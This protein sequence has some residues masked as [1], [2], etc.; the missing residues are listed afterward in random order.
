MLSLGEPTFKKKEL[1]LIFL[2]SG[3]QDAFAGGR[4]C[5][6][7]RLLSGCGATLI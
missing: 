4:E 2:I 6:P 3:R 5:G 7:M 1:L